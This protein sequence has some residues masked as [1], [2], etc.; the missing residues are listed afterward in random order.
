MIQEF[1]NDRDLYVVLILAIPH[2]LYCFIW[3]NAPTFS[4]I[5][6][7]IGFKDSVRPFAAFAG[8][9]K[10][11]QGAVFLSR[12][13]HYSANFASFFDHLKAIPVHLWVIALALIIAGQTLNVAIYHAIGIDGVYYGFL[14]GKV[15]ARNHQTYEIPNILINRWFYVAENRLG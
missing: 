14:L 13:F 3:K 5:V 8:W 4:K 2:L 1:L 6:R 12:Y 9:L 10:V 15:S 7:S 11:A